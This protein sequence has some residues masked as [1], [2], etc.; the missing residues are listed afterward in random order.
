ME[1]PHGA[2]FQRTPASGSGSAQG[3]NLRPGQF[4]AFRSLAQ[5]FGIP[6]NSQ[7][8]TQAWPNVMFIAAEMPQHGHSCH[9][10][11]QGY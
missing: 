8:V 11:A 1:K 4:G 10:Q 5:S 2:R 9:R 6:V 7:S 3:F